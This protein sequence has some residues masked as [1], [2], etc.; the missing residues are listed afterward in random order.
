LLAPE[1]V[2]EADG[3]EA[4]DLVLAD[5]R[6]DQVIAGVA[7]D[8]EERGLV[9]G[10]LRRR[11]GDV[12]ALRYRHEVFGD[13]EDQGLFEAVTGFCARMSQVRRHLEQIAKMT[14]AEQ[15]GGWFLDA[16]VIYCGAVRSLGA[17][18]AARPVCSRGLLA[19]RDYLA[20]YLASP[21][22]AGLTAGTAA[23]RAELAKITYL[24]RVKGLRVEVSRYDGEPDYSAEIERTF[25]RF[26]QGAVKDYR[27][28]YRGWPGM[29][30][31]GAQI[32]KLVARLFPAEFSA[33]EEF[34]RRHASFLD[35]TIRQF[36]REVQFYLA[37]LD[38]IRPL[39]A[40]GLGFCLPELAV[41]SKEI[42]ARDT[43]D[44]ALAAKLV[45]AGTP[46][47]WARPTSPP[48]TSGTPAWACAPAASSATT[49][50]PTACGW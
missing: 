35:A 26:R 4:D 18:L 9:A 41:G 1:P 49:S 42:L 34:C 28:K 6:L 36:D 10:L 13:L 8:L 14:S 21:G 22:F 16:A 38:F 5:L 40:A 43:F 2:V 11:A 48:P 32:A 50:T 31:V 37:Y 46:V 20:C 23:R 7:G 29:N 12:E 24:I 25:E 17:D 44:L 47:A 27:V 33:L 3:Y 15:R 30:H 39:R 19:F 45:R